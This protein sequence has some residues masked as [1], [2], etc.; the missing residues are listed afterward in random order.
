MRSSFDGER[1]Y[2][3]K[4]S[5]SAKATQAVCKS[6]AFGAPWNPCAV[7][8]L[9]QGRRLASSFKAH[10][11]FLLQGKRMTFSC[12]AHSRFL[13]QERRMA[14]SSF[15][16]HARSSFREGAGLPSSRHTLGSFFREGAWLL[17]QS[18]CTLSSSGKAKGFL[19]RG[20]LPLP[21]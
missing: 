10:S 12:K 17:L 7:C 5:I 19:L 4:Q 13:R 2:S 21:P 11:R 14:V 20:T 8:F 9:L 3:I 16:A 6:R 1:F 15:K 18:T